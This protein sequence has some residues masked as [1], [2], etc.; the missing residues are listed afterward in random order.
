MVHEGCT[1]VHCADTRRIE[2][3]YAMNGF[4]GNE[5]QADMSF[6]ETD[7]TSADSAMQP[8]TV[9]KDEDTKLVDVLM[10]ASRL[11]R[12]RLASLSEER[13]EAEEKKNDQVRI[14]KLL[15]LKPKMT[16]KEMAELLGMRLRILDEVLSEMQQSGYVNRELPQ[17]PDMRAVAVS[18]S[19][20]GRDAVEQGSL[21]SD[22]KELVPELSQEDRQDLIDLLSE[23]NSALE[24]LGLSDENRSSHSDCGFD[25]NHGGRDGRGYHDRHDS[26]GHGGSDNRGARSGRGSYGHGGRDEHS[27]R[28]G[29][30]HD[31][32]RYS[33]HGRDSRSG[34]RSSSTQSARYGR[35]DRGNYG[36]DRDGEQRGGFKR[37]SS[38]HGNYDNSHRERHD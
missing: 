17:E 11:M 1:Y 3:R 4:E 8:V 35:G 10:K 31:D 15:Q 18:L 6:E 12:Q 23:V 13:K 19:S 28:G 16:Q 9:E 29:Y 38:W 14:L 21:A 32:H 7:K 34:Y 33:S 2:R 20:A 27:G 25:T 30:G 22:K 5:E 26:Y 37:S 24:S 36:H